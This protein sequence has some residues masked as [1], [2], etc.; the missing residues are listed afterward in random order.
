MSGRGFLPARV[1]H[2]SLLIAV[3]ALFCAGTRLLTIEADE[4]WSLVSA[5]KAMGTAR[6]LPYGIDNPVVTSGGL[7]AVLQGVLSRLDQGILLHR[8]VSIGFA[9][10][11]IAVVHGLLTRYSPDRTVVS[12]GLCFFVAAPGW[13]LVAP[14]ALAEI[15]ASTILLLSFVYWTRQG[16]LSLASTLLAG[17][18]F[19]LACATRMTCLGALPA[20]FIWSALFQSN[21]RSRF[22]YPGLAIAIAVLVFAGLTTLYSLMFG[23]SNVAE[24]LSYLKLSTGLYQGQ[25]LERRINFLLSANAY[26]PALGIMAIATWYARGF[27]VHR[28]TEAYRLGALLVLSG[29]LLWVSWLFK[30]PIA[31]VRY[32][33]PAIP[34]LWLS[35]ILAGFIH[36]N[37]G[38]F[39]RVP[40][41]VHAIVVAACVIQGLLS[42]R[43]LAVS[44][45]LTLAYELSG[46]APLSRFSQPFEARSNQAAMARQLSSLDAGSTVFAFNPLAAIPGTYESGRRILS[47]HSAPS[48]G[49]RDYVL[50]LPSDLDL[51]KP[52]W[53]AIA[54]IENNTTLVQAY[55]DY[56]LRSVNKD[57]SGLYQ[58]KQSSSQ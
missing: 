31:H 27:R 4:A 23:V 19:G 37:S 43:A 32:L 50:L 16:G 39:R 7:Y 10:G 55:G 15:I 3:F 5:A 56:V 1:L 21:W 57:S 18:L 22:L 12:L 47:I 51:F 42:L 14:L 13:Y 38:T 24:F 48:F 40:G 11:L 36:L 6:A 17:T 46:R 52:A 2:Y 49:S 28:G 53:G 9:L 58:A 34:F 30:A 33:W 26:L 8:M 29:I 44:E 35:V 41:F 45:S 25:R 20:V 54:W